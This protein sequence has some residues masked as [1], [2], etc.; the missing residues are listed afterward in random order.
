VDV[1]RTIEFIIRSQADAEVRDARLGRR[2]DGLTTIVKQGMKMLVVLDKRMNQLAVAQQET[3]VAMRELAASQKATDKK[4]QVFL[5][6]LGK[7]GN[8]RNGRSK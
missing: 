5:D 3:T 4:F 6:S 7:G 1:E 8:G 2:I